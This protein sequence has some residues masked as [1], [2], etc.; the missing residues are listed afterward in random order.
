MSDSYNPKRVIEELNQR[1]GPGARANIRS[2]PG[3]TEASLVQPVLFY[4]IKIK[5]FLQK[6]IEYTHTFYSRDIFLNEAEAYNFLP[7]Y[8]NA[9]IKNNDLPSHVIKNG[10]PDPEYL[11]T[12]L[13]SLNIAH[14]EKVQEDEFVKNIK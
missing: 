10:E 4:Q 2:Q 12:G 1:L 11:R 9:L 14:V 8:I 13:V 6:P 7:I 3:L 5:R